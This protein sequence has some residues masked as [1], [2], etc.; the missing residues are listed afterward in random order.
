MEKKNKKYSIRGILYYKMILLC[1]VIYFSVILYY[2]M[3]FFIQIISSFVFKILT[4]EKCTV[5]PII[6]GV[7][8]FL[9]FCSPPI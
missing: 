3:N 2:I 1:L 6:L 4:I 5:Q 8:I 9:I 7:V